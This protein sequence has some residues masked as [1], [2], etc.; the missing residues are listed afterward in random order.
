M[1]E[2]TKIESSSCGKPDGGCRTEVAELPFYVQK[3]SNLM[4]FVPVFT[5]IHPLDV[6]IASQQLLRRLE[7]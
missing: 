6:A 1:N 4:H 7:V 5:E 3:V 2:T